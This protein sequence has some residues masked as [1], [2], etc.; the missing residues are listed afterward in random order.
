MSSRNKSSSPATLAVLNHWNCIPRKWNRNSVRNFETQTIFRSR[1]SSVPLFH[2]SWESPTTDVHC[3]TLI[4][5]RKMSPLIDESNLISPSQTNLWKMIPRNR[6]TVGCHLTYG[7]EGTCFA[8]VLGGF[9][10]SR[11]GPKKWELSLAGKAKKCGSRSRPVA[12]VVRPVST[13]VTVH[14]ERW[15]K[16]RKQKSLCAFSNQLYYLYI[17]YTRRFS[18]TVALAPRLIASRCCI[19]IYG[20]P[21]ARVQCL[22]ATRAH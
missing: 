19:Y 2:F 14:R 17:T 6:L 13:V 22:V 11:L 7:C 3:V 12:L 8:Y 20:M 9:D 10:W 4:W 15:Q 21:G 16:L 1:G 5:L 18:V